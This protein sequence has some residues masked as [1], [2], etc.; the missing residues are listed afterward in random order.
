MSDT[1]CF[2]KFQFFQNMSEQ[3]KLQSTQPS[4]IMLLKGFSHDLVRRFSI[5]LYFTQLIPSSLFINL[6][7]YQ[8]FYERCK[9]H[10]NLSPSSKLPGFQ[11]KKN[12]RYKNRNIISAA[13]QFLPFSIPFTPILINNI[14]HLKD[15]LTL[16]MSTSK[17]MFCFPASAESSTLDPIGTELIRTRGFSSFLS[18]RLYVKYYWGERNKFT[19]SSNSFKYQDEK[20]VGARIW[21]ESTYTQVFIPSW[22]S[23]SSEFTAIETTT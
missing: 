9:Q 12:K 13:W 10:M 8:S 20:M 16:K 11:V 5:I 1:N 21:T 22:S 7:L 17:L 23:F 2:W 14:F 19:Y 15:K 4:A 18:L 3:M 6:V